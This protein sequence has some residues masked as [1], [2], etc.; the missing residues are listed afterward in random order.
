VGHASRSSNLL[1]LKASQTR[2]FQFVSR[3]VEARRWVVQ[4]TPSR[5]LRQCKVE[6]DGSIRQVASDPVT[7]ALPFS[8]Y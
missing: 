6:D 7:I 4:V 5:R 8:F 3:L 2:V 1:C